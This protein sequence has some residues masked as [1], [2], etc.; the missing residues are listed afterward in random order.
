MLPYS[1]GVP[2]RIG[3]RSI[4]SSKGLIVPSKFYGIAAAGKAD[5]RHRRQD[6]R[7]GANGAAARLR[8]RRHARRCGRARRHVT[9]ACRRAGIGKRAG[10]A[11]A[12]DARRALHAA[13]RTSRGGANCSIA[14][15]IK[16]R[17]QGRRRLVKS[18][19]QFE[20]KMPNRSKDQ[21]G[22]AAIQA[23]AER[24]REG[25]R[26]LRHRAR[27]GF[28]RLVGNF[29]DEDI[30]FPLVDVDIIHSL[31]PFVRQLRRQVTRQDEKFAQPPATCPLNHRLRWV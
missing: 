17:R 16:T 13:A 22:R 21:S 20:N 11:S 30:F 25:S 23:G 28:Q 4:R 9:A 6:R 19:H 15:D 12:H 31:V 18:L 29:T 5:R 10:P 3:C 27:R 8:R 26:L 2:M 14:W 1:L 7:S 24:K